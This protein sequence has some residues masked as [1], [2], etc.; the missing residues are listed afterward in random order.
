MFHFELL[1]IFA[2]T[3]A[4]FH[5]FTHWVLDT[6]L[7]SW[8]TWLLAHA[9]LGWTTLQSYV[10]PN[11]KPWL[12]LIVVPGWYKDLALISAVL[13]RVRGRA[14]DIARHWNNVGPFDNQIEFISAAMK[15]LS[16][17][18]FGSQIIAGTIFNVVKIG[19]DGISMNGFAYF[20]L[21][22]IHLTQRAS[23]PDD[24]HSAYKRTVFWNWFLLAMALLSSAAFFVANGY[25]LGLV[26]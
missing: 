21:V 19:L 7:F 4:D 5:R 1:P 14:S 23:M 6:F 17:A 22:N 8:I 2:N 16:H 20:L 9:W 15:K 25:A 3:L 12:P 10:F 11:I 13:S 18:L 26:H 24:L